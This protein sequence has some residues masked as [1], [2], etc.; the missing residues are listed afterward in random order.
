MGMAQESSEEQSTTGEEGSNN[1]HKSSSNSHAGNGNNL[2]Q[3]LS[4]KSPLRCG[5]CQRPCTHSMRDETVVNIPHVK[6]YSDED[7]SPL[8]SPRRSVPYEIQVKNLSYHTVPSRAST[9]VA[10]FVPKN[11]WPELLQ[12]KTILRNVNCTAKPGELLA[13]A[14]PSGAGKSTLLEI[15]AGR[16]TPAKNSSILVNKRPM[17]L[18]SFRRI[19]G[20]VMQH[21]LLFPMLTVAETLM[22]SAQ[23]RLPSSMPASAKRARVE[24][25]MAEL[26]LRGVASSRIGSDAVRGVSGG[27]RRRVSIGVD[28]IHDPAVL[29]L[30]EPTSG[31]D[32]AAALQVVAMLHNMA[33]SH[34]RTIILSIHQPGFRILELIHSI[35]LLGPGRMIHSGSLQELS[36]KLFAAGHSFPP[37]VN[38]VEYAIE[39]INLIE[40]DRGC[41]GIIAECFN[42]PVSKM[43]CSLEDLFNQRVHD[44]SPPPPPPSV[45]AAPRIVDKPTFANSRCREILLLSSRCWKTIWRTKQL[46]LART[47]QAL[48]AGFALGSVFTHLGRNVVGVRERYGFF[49]FTLTFLLTSTSESLPMFL[50]ERQ[51]FE[52][53]TS[54]GTYRVSSYVIANT[55]MFLPF[56][57]VFSLLYTVPAYFLVGL[58]HSIEAYVFFLLDVWMVVVDANSIVSFFSA[59]VPDYILGNTLVTGTLGAFFLFSGYFVPKDHIPK[60]WL[61]MHYLS[62]FKY[63][64]DAMLINEYESL[65]DVCFAKVC[66]LTGRSV[67]VESGLEHSSK[68]MNLGVSAI[69]A[70]VYRL[71]AYLVLRF[72]PRHKQQ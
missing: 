63:P 21:D 65:S 9:G 26:G 13:I 39:T 57:F 3:V 31:L 71:L 33:K 23:L 36:D 56:L 46:S 47:A 29:L 5:A 8:H 44:K 2:L 58:N 66:N 22:C 32:S 6:L 17:E 69:F 28:V 12:T 45:F 52:R 37:Q 7:D 19:S 48:G 18:S 24:L 60:Y 51:I 16:I 59:L 10:C 67:L 30:D 15:L 55:L 41:D 38:V 40:A 34:E 62:V 35:V 50:A 11:Y 72:K 4:Q 54:R 49:A 64:L 43:R 25:L 53:E 1:T 70:V 42:V 20:Y 61:F 14:G 68:W 27:E